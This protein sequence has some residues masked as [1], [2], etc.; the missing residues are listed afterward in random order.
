MGFL[1]LLLS[2]LPSLPV[3]ASSLQTG[4]PESKTVPS[5]TADA[6]PVVV[7]LFTSEGCSSCPPADLFL[8]KLDQYQPIEGAQLIVLSE[9][10]TYWDHD[11]WKDPNSS[12]ALTDRQT[13]YELP[14]GEKECFT[15]QIIID[16]DREVTLQNVPHLEEVLKQARD[17]AKIPVHIGAVSVD[18]SN[19]ALLRAHVDTGENLTKHNADVYLAVALNRV[20]SQVLK[21]ENGGR[22]LVHVAVVQRII[23]VGRLSKG[24]SYAEDLQ[25]KLTPAEDPKNLRVIAFV[26]E[27]GPGKILGAV[28]QKLTN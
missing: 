12:A 27:P 18:P 4:Q 21:G 9:H 7:E 19:S 14:L 11:G 25:V 15:P 17:E 28:L 24:K 26:Q 6:H 20:E 16:G 8:Q 23:K 13:S 3:A 1:L 22:H 5:S 2:S 10:V